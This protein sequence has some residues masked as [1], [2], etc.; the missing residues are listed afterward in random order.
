MDFKWENRAFFPGGITQ[1]KK[2]FSPAELVDIYIKANPHIMKA[3]QEKGFGDKDFEY[4]LSDWKNDFLKSA[5]DIGRSIEFFMFSAGERLE[6]DAA[7]KELVKTY[8]EARHDVIVLAVVALY[9][10]PPNQFTICITALEHLAENSNLMVY[11]RFLSLISEL[12]KAYMIILQDA[13]SPYPFANNA[14]EKVV[15]LSSIKPL[16][17]RLDETAREIAKIAERKGAECD[18]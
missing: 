15:A 4:N 1:R 11:Y 5:N 9:N 16:E 14:E 2:V 7:F 10:C 18:T 6:H 17:Q 3:M 13:D 12:R 8:L